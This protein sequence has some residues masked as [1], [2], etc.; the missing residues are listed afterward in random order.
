MVVITRLAKALGIEQIL[1][2]YA[3]ASRLIGVSGPIP[4]RWY[5][6]CPCLGKP[7]ARVEHDVVGHDEVS[8]ARNPQIGRRNAPALE[9]IYLL[10][11]N[12]G[13]MTTPLPITAITLGLKIPDGTR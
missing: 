7:P 11:E 9:I 13:S 10:P 3:L 12:G 2:A 4:R 5:R 6:S 1:H 8:P